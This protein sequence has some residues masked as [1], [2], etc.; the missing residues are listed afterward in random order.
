MLSNIKEIR[1][2]KGVGEK[3]AE[4]L[5]KL[6]ISSGDALLSF[7]PRAYR[8]LSEIT[9]LENA[10]LDDVV[11]IKGEIVSPVTEHYIRKNMTL[12]K[13]S[14]KSDNEILYNWIKR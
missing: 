4:L 7:Y 3:R 2:L 12:Y 13:F 1:Y 5:K 11:C 14:V 10:H 6:G 8:D 9:P